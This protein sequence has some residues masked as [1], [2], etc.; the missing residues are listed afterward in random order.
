M[1][2]PASCLSAELGPM[3]PRVGEL[4][5]ECRGIW[6]TAPADPPPLGKRY[7]GREKR[8]VE[9]ELSTFVERVTERGNGKQGQASPSD[10]G[11]LE[12]TIAALRPSGR[13]LLD[14]MELPLGSIYDERFVDSTRRFLAAARGFDPGLGLDSVYQALRNV[15]IMNTLQLEMGLEVE[16][17]D[18]VF[19]YSMVYPYL[20]NLLD[21]NTTPT[22]EKL[23]TLDKLRAWLEGKPAKPGDARE[24]KL[25][26]LVAKVEGRFPRAGHPGV[27]RSMLSIY[28]AQILSLLQ[29]RRESAPA[30][31][32]V[33]AVAG[34][35][36]AAPFDNIV[37]ISFEKGGTSV[38]ADGYLVAGR[39]D[40]DQERFCFG[41]GAFLQLADDLQDV[42]EDAR[43][44][45]MTV[46]SRA[47]VRGETLDPLL[48]R[49]LRFMAAV[50]ERNPGR[51]RPD[52][53]RLR[54]LMLRAC[55]L[56][57]L[58]SAGKCRDRFSRKGLRLFQES[59]P[60][61]FSY[62]RKLRRKIEGRFLD[63]RPTIADA[64]PVLTA[65]LSLS[66]RALALD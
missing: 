8:A 53:I 25:R 66:S 49:Y 19:G 32:A 27:Y 31:A 59:F 16:H 40:P 30:G 65:F 62:L 33:G 63:G 17:T 46:F 1:T 12:E 28:N 38:L 15:W 21:D 48:F 22:R 35:A 5:R 29:Q 52:D 47:A 58:E 9:R 3:G 54:A 10:P 50:L 61:R 4:V 64:D 20:D 41:F 26:A 36:S 24:E 11:E 56:M 44:G 37:S 39:L 14:L 18:A 23:V 7:A 51:G 6:E 2:D 13:R 42:E 45:H 57:A 60:A 43:R 55:T 34:A